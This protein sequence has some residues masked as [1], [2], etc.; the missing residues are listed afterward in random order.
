MT[1][2]HHNEFVTICELE[3][4][5][6]AEECLHCPGDHVTLPSGARHGVSDCSEGVVLVP[7]DALSWTSDSEYQGSVGY[8]GYDNG[9]AAKGTCG[10]PYS[11]HGLGGGWQLCFA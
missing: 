2:E 1:V 5:V 9:C 4:M 7:G 10:L 3:A 11:G 6:A 8:N